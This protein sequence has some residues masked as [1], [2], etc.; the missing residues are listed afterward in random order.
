MSFSDIVR[1]NHKNLE[2]ALLLAEKRWLFKHS[3]GGEM[4]VT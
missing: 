3:L 4:V 2:P 1:I